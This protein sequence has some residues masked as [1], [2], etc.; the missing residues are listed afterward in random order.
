MD[1]YNPI[2]VKFAINPLGSIVLTTVI[3]FVLALTYFL[4][5]RKVGPRQVPNKFLLMVGG[6]V[7]FIKGLVAEVIG[8]K[9]TKLTPY[10]L[11]LFIWLATSNLIIL[12]G[13]KE[14]ATALTVPLVFA[15]TTW[16]GSQVVAV[17]Y[18]KWSYF[19]KFLIR[20]KIGN[21]KIPVLINPLEVVAKI[22]PII[23][24]TFRM[25]GN[26]TAGS[27]IY[28]L[29][30]WA[31]AGITDPYPQIGILLITATIIMPFLLGYFTMFAGLIQAFV[32]TLLSITYWGQE[33]Q[34]GIHHHE[35]LRKQ[36]EEKLLIQ[37][38]ALDNHAN[39]LKNLNTNSISEL[40]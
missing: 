25:W 27:I 18:Q 35:E 6:L 12:L 20:I 16:I 7:S 32:F 1:K 9:H 21:V 28:A 11:F 23:S 8:P 5:I 19:N 22:T 30:W 39:E 13:F 38:Q 14:T 10:F 3:V 2:S 4:M 40:A 33:I 29:V 26:I 31:F 24:L 15:I 37:K 36:K 34:E 17:K